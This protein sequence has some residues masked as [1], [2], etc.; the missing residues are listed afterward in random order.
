METNIIA[1]VDQAIAESILHDSIVT[2]RPETAEEA[3]ALETEL[4][5]QGP[6]DTAEDGPVLQFWGTLDEGE[7]DRDWRVH[8]DRSRVITPEAAQ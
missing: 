7:G 2:L 1:I 6:D 5:S 3:E 8:I 4:Y